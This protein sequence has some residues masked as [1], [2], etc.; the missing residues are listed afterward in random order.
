M[1]MLKVKLVGVDVNVLVKEFDNSVEVC[2][3]EKSGVY[4]VDIGSRGEIEKVS[5]VSESDEVV[6][7][8][9]EDIISDMMDG[10]SESCREYY[11]EFCDGYIN[12]FGYYEVLSEE[13]CLLYVNVI[14]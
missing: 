9:K 8:E 14:V 11:D 4:C 10:V 13:N 3:F 1:K 2:D 6:L 7:R 12:D 5:F